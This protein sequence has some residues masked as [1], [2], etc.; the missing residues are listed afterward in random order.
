MV[1][2]DEP[3]HPETLLDDKTAQF[4]AIMGGT[5]S[6]TLHWTNQIPSQFWIWGLGIEK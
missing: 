4:M 6:Y 2:D 5:H 3:D 1:R